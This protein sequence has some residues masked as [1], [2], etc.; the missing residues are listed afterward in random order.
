MEIESA[1]KDLTVQKNFAMEVASKLT[2]PHRSMRFAS[3]RRSM[4]EVKATKT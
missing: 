1:D 4:V 2:D 3:R